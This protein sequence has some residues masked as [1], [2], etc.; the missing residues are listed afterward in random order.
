MVQ[1]FLAE[2][3]SIECCVPRVWCVGWDG[4]GVDGTLWGCGSTHDLFHGR[5]GGLADVHVEVG[6]FNGKREKGGRRRVT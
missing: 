4:H 5:I 3:G 1:G 6:R 2:R